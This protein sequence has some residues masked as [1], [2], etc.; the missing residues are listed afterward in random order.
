MVVNP[1][2]VEHTAIVQ[3]TLQKAGAVRLKLMQAG[4]GRTLQS[5]ES[6]EEATQHR[7]ELDMTHQTAGTYLILAEAEHGQAVKKIV[8]VTN[9]D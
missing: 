4:D 3:V 5:L 8:K 1:N 7:F 9:R 6:T 2:P